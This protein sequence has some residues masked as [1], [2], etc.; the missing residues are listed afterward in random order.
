M[1]LP[2]TA[3]SRREICARSPISLF[4]AAADGETR[5]CGLVEHWVRRPKAQFLWRRHADGYEL[6][7]WIGNW[8]PQECTGRLGDRD[9]SR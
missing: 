3:P 4:G 2:A 9:S 8:E 6:V 7:A 5:D 1:R